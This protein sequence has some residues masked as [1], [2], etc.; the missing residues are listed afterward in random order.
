MTVPGIGQSILTSGK[1]RQRADCHIVHLDEFW[2]G[3]LIENGLLEELSEPM[4]KAGLSTEFTD[5]KQYVSAAHDIAM[6]RVI[7]DK[8][9]V[10]KYA[11]KDADPA[12]WYE[13][14]YAVP[15]RNNCGILCCDPALVKEVAEG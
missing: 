6:Y 5:R 3:Q 13:R 4:E 8:G 9:L 12:K 15:A 10:A 14:R 1:A 2:L 11:I 7:R